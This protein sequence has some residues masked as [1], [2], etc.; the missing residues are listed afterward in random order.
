MIVCARRKMAQVFVPP[1]VMTAEDQV[2][3]FV[4]RRAVVSAAD[5]HTIRAT[6][7]ESPTIG[8]SGDRLWRW[9]C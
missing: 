1:A 2:Q 9:E 4:G 6:R 5:W 3:S 8:Y 7:C